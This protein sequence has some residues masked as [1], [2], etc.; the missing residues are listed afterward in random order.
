MIGLIFFSLPLRVFLFPG[1]GVLYAGSKLF[2]NY[3][4]SCRV[5]KLN[6][7]ME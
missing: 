3:V 6:T 1:N 5:S 4:P 2:I 7:G